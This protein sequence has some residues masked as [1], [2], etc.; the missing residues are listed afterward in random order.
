M[1]FRCTSFEVVVR[2]QSPLQL[3][4][5]CPAGRFDIFG[6]RP[7]APTA[8]PSRPALCSSSNEQNNLP[9]GLGDFFHTAPSNGLKF[10]REICAANQR[11]R[12]RFQRQRCRFGLQARILATT[13]HNR[14]ANNAALRQTLSDK[15]RRFSPPVSRPRL[16]DPTQG[17]IFLFAAPQKSCM[18]RAGISFFFLRPPPQSPD[19]SFSRAGEVFVD[20][21]RAIFSPQRRI[22][23]LPGFCEVTPFATPRTTL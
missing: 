9:F 19:Q 3:L 1:Y 18:K 8:A 21:P 14:P 15:S 16:A 7:S 5:A 11:V 23:P 13:P 12:P 6:N 22:R 2:A 17:F 10:P 4:S 20:I